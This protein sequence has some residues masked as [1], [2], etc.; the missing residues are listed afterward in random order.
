MPEP[1]I[2]PDLFTPEEAA[3]YLH[4]DSVRSLDTLRSDFGLVGYSGVNK[5]YMYHRDDLDIV[6]RRICKKD[7]SW[8]RNETPQLRIAGGRR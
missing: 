8:S 2:H 4:L 3:I 7:Q 1:R 6:A 5:A